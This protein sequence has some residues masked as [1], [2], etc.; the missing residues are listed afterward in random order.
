MIY[1]PPQ[2]EE[3]ARQMVH[4]SQDVQEAI[5]VISQATL[6]QFEQLKKQRKETRS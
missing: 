4:N 5:E 1:V 6:A 2:L 3:L